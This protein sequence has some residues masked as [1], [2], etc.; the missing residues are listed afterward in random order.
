MLL[1]GGCSIYNK[2]VMSKM[3]IISF[4]VFGQFDWRLRPYS[5]FRQYGYDGYRVRAVS[6]LIRVSYSAGALRSLNKVL[7]VG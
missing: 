6:A 1:C 7:S 2:V 4:A 3:F 5:W